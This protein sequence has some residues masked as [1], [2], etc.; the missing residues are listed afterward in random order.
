VI[1]YICISASA[2]VLIIAFMRR[3]QWVEL[4]TKFSRFTTKQN[5]NNQTATGS[6]Y[7]LFNSKEHASWDT[8]I[9]TPL[10][11]TRAGSMIE[12]PYDAMIGTPMFQDSYR[13][14]YQSLDERREEIL[15]TL[16]SV[17]RTPHPDPDVISFVPHLS[18]SS[19]TFK[20]TENSQH[21]KSKS[22]VV[23]V[24][25]LSSAAGQDSLNK[26]DIQTEKGNIQVP[27]A[28]DLK[29]Q[30]AGVSRPKARIDYL[31]GLVAMASL[32]VTA[33]HFCLTFATAAINPDAYPHNDSEIWARKTVSSYFLNLNWIGPFLMT[34]TRFL[35]SS[36]LRTGNL[37][38]L[39]EKTLGRPFRLIIPI[40]VIAILEY[41][42]M[43]SGATMWLEYMASVTWSTWPFTVRQLFPLKLPLI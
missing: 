3:V 33:I 34:S 39:A 7:D 4:T 28:A 36:Y 42:L 2:L 11:T 40:A 26:S 14:G 22:V 21:N 16:Q 10:A 13:S 38:N 5:G 25:S 32:L 43:D 41:F 30:N 17:P 20:T 31:A 19:I 37:R 24:T 27:T 8:P 18:S 12:T 6:E 9:E 23:S 29:E 15:M 1:L 35:V